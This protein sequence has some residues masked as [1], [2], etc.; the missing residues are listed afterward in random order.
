MSILRLLARNICS[1]SITL[2]YPER[3]AIHPHFRGMVQNNSEECTGC[4]MCAYV[5]TSGAITVQRTAEGFRW[6]YDPGQCTFCARC[7]QRCPKKTLSMQG[8]RPPVYEEHGELR[9]FH[10]ITKKK[11]LPVAP[12]MVVASSENVSPDAVSSDVAASAQT[13]GAL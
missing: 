3:P 4:G 9:Q 7:T 6:N 8:T 12:P 11:K 13:A 10:E 5:C 1:G 2:P